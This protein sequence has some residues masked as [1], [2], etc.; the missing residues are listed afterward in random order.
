MAASGIPDKELLAL[1]QLILR[2]INKLKLKLSSIKNERDLEVGNNSLRG[3][4]E[5]YKEQ[6]MEIKSRGLAWYD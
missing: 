2:E 5:M 4:L 1:N 3:L 6:D